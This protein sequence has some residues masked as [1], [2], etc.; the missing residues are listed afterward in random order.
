MFR[1]DVFVQIVE[2][3]LDLAVRT[4]S[5]SA[6]SALALECSPRARSTHT[7]TYNRLQTLRRSGASLNVETKESK[8]KLDWLL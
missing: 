1:S 4:E 2:C 8:S 3:P 7:F 6:L 5:C